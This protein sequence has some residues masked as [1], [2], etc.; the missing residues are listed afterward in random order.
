M[1]RR[2][3]NWTLPPEI[4]A[5]LGESSYGRQRAMLEASHLLVILHAPPAQ[6]RTEREELVLLRNPDGR[7]LANGFEGGEVRLR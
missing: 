4:E 7:W 1:K 3:F 5:R 2:N 6:E